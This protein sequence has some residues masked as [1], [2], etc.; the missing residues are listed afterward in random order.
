M[1]PNGPLSVK[2]KLFAMLSG[3][4][5]LFTALLWITL[6]NECFLFHSNLKTDR[7]LH[8]CIFPTLND[9]SAAN[10]PTLKQVPFFFCFFFFVV[11][12]LFCFF[13][14][15][16][17][18]LFVCFCFCFSSWVASVLPGSGPPSTQLWRKHRTQPPSSNSDPSHR[19]D[20]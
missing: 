14:F 15:V 11:F 9:D 16:L 10:C 17:F 7:V 2:T 20:F 4:L 1:I 6:N 18:C 3:N 12:F 8:K 5:L 13:L 19:V